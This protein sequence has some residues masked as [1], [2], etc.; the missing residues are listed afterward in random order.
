MEVH[1][2]HLNITYF[3]FKDEH[4]NYL[5]SGNKLKLNPL[6][7]RRPKEYM[8]TDDEVSQM[9][10]YYVIPLQELRNNYPYNEA[11]YLDILDYEDDLMA[12]VD[13]FVD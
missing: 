7:H 9:L 6:G 12:F 4:Y 1:M 13:H 2:K 11:V 8:L 5:L 3:L 10:D